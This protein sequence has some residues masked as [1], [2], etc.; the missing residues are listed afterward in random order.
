MKSS[1]Y[2]AVDL[3]CRWQKNGQPIDLILGP[4]V[5]TLTDLRD[6]QLVKAIVFGVLR[7]CASLDWVVGQYSKQPLKKIKK[8]VL[9]GLRVGVYQLLFMDRVPASAAVNETIK[10]LKALKQ[11]RWITGFAN[12]VLRNVERHKD[13]LLLS[14]RS[15]DIPEL[16]R[17]NHPEWLVCRWKERYGVTLLE[18]ICRSN[19]SSAALCLRVNSLKIAVEDFQTMLTQKNIDFSVGKYVSEAIWISGDVGM[20]ENLPGFSDG[21]FSVQD[22][23]AQLLCCLLSPLEKGAYLDG[24]AGLGGKTA[25]MAQLV[26]PESRIVAVE[27]TKQRLELLGENIARL[28]LKGVEVFE[29]TLQEFAQQAGDSFEAVLI[30]AP[31]SGIGVTGRHPD[32]RWLRKPEEL[33][34]YQKKQLEL[35]NSASGLVGPGGVVVYATCSTEPEENDEVVELFLQGNSKFKMES[36]QLFLSENAQS[37]VDDKGFLRTIPGD[38]VSDG[39][40]AARLVRK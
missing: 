4:S 25:V 24:C 10:A 15:G 27:P 1:R 39:F 36:A 35:L 21:F 28:D 20:V 32:I 7:N 37:L 14:I 5:E 29:G 2:I 12:G 23:M 8:A 30:D 22:E 19:N 3:L 11:P 31:C 9:Q 13:E 33:Q 17:L 26:P 40:F 38:K 34:R 16:A 18:G 6:R